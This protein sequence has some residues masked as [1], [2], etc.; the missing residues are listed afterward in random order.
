M[1]KGHRDNHQARVNRGP[2][3]FK[4]KKDRRTV[5]PTCNVCGN[6][7]RKLILNRCPKCVERLGTH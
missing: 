4:K 7:S 1:S 5:E 2:V 3:A 6:H